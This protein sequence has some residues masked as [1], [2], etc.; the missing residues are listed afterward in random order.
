MNDQEKV[1]RPTWPLE[2]ITSTVGLVVLISVISLLMFV[3]G[4]MER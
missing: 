2:A 3:V 4:Q 1:A